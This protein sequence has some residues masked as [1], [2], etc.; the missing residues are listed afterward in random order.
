MQRRHGEPSLVLG[1]IFNEWL[2]VRA[3][4]SLLPVSAGPV[5]MTDD[6]LPATTALKPEARSFHVWAATRTELCESTPYFRSFQGGI[7]HDSESG[8]IGYLL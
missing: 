8:L 1:K 6:A 3:D 5:E 7:H 2:I 4:I